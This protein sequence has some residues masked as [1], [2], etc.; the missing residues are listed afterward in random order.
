MEAAA[1]ALM[2]QWAQGRVPHYSP[3][4][5]RADA[6]KEWP[7]IAPSPERARQLMEMWLDGLPT[8]SI[9]ALL[10]YLPLACKQTCVQRLTE[11]LT[12]L[13]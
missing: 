11:W 6:D 4:K 10:G 2:R 8:S 12:K 1:E 3:H 7:H 13:N 5:P 9:A